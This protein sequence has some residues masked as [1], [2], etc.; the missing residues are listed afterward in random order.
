MILKLINETDA[1][2]I[3]CIFDAARKSFRNEIYGAYKAHRPPPPPELIPQFAIVRDA[4]RGRDRADLLAEPR[5]VLPM[6]G[7]DH[8]LAA[9]RMPTLLPD[10]RHGRAT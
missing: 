2:A 10:G 3:A 1:D 8:P 4:A 6:R 7:D 5:P 9:Q